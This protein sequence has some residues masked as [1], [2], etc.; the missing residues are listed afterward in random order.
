MSRVLKKQRSQKY[1]YTYSELN[2]PV[3]SGE[4][5]WGKMLV[6]YENAT[7]VETRSKVLF[8]INT[9]LRVV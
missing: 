3:R 7:T 2:F 1:T 8:T 6:E 9:R 5:L 4:N